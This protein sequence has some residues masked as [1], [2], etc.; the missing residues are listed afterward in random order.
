M[1]KK[2]LKKIANLATDHTW[3]MG[4]I[5]LIITFIFI[6]LMSQLSMNMNMTSL[7]PEGDPMVDEFN[8]IFE[9]FNGSSNVFIVA[10]GDFEDM[11][12]YAEALKPQILD[13]DN[14]IINN[15]S[16]EL[17]EQ[18]DK[19]Q[20]KIKAGKA[21]SKD[22]LFERVDY[23]QPLDYMRDHGLMLM[24]PSDIK[25]SREMFEDPNF[26]P[27]LVNLN[28]SLEK[29]YIQ[30]EEKISTQQKE[31]GA[32]AFLDGI[33][34]WTDLNT[35]YYIYGEKDVQTLA[36]ES[37]EALTLGSPYFISPDRSML[38]IQAMPTFSMM[39]MN[40]LLPGVNAIEECAKSLATEHN[41]EVGL[42]GSIVLGRDEY[43]AGLADSM[44]L[45][46]I[47]LVGIFV[48]FIVTFRM[49]AAPLLAITNLIIG[50]IWAMGFTWF[51]VDE[52]NMFTAMM[53]VVLVGLGIDYSIH[54]I[55]VYSELRNKGVV[56]RE[57]ME[58]T[59]EK[60][61]AGIITGAFT[62]S[63]AFFTLIIARSSG[64][65]EFGLVNGVGLVVVMIATL[66]TLPVMLILRE[67]YRS[68]RKK[69]FKQTR[70]VSYR[71]A[72]KT[73]VLIRN[74]RKP[75]FII[76]ALV[77]ILALFYAG[78]VTMDY[79]YLNMEPEGL[80]SILLNEE[81]IEAF[82]MSSDQTLM[83]ATSLEENRRFEQEAKEKHSISFVES[84][85]SFL[86]LES[87]Q[88]ERAVG[89]Q[90]IHDKMASTKIS[91]TP[92]HNAWAL[93]IDELIRLE[94]N[95]IELQDLSFIGGQDMVDKKATRLVGNP[96]QPEIQGKLTHLIAKLEEIGPKEEM[97]V[98]WHQAFAPAYREIV[99]DMADVSILTLADLPS[100]ISEKFISKD[101]SRYLMTIYPKGNVWHIDYLE[102]HTE[103]VLDISTSIAGMP[104]M[105]YYLLKIMGA[106][107]A[108]A[109]GL[110]IIVVIFFLWLDFRSLKK[111]LL[112]LVPLAFGLVW[113]LGIMGLTGVQFTL[114]N[115]IALP[116]IVGIGI[117]DGVH[118]IHRYE[119]EGPKGL[120]TV[121]ASTG[122]AVII[123]SLTTMI[124]F[125]SLVF[126]V[127]RG[128]G[129]MGIALFIG[130]GVCLAAS[131]LI[132]PA[133]LGKIEE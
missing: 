47:A 50:I 65:S 29:E 48:L 79:N 63:A 60:V 95:V 18:I 1:R 7:L 123:T 124:S 126:A 77:T 43:V 12:S 13:L 88:K 20:E 125:G 11:I 14:W 119:L 83:T 49:L 59:L 102:Q 33:E 51:L 112:A 98:K 122:K 45:T 128:F 120:Y 101:G 25:N 57:A 92:G 105:F 61:G 19:L 3:K 121:F 34:S 87:E 111:A 89:V 39:D 116:L 31:R 106:D 86:P 35:R 100:D 131:L 118:I 78:Q 85:T 9:E 91:T 68:M 67:K 80:E 2:L 66:M 103:D 73:A 30:S 4:G 84:I 99:L 5:L 107:G 113:M 132:L 40:Y 58:K 129:S 104:P 71:L 56:V 38:I 110:T 90:A 69:E 93:F 130:V 16:D 97:L 27:F 94:A 42:T 70:D 21:E 24:K 55:S 115:I 52:L 64:M 36:A 114:L 10:K 37:A 53:A 17:K 108:R 127:Y 81:L 8:Y 109:M 75:S 44:S 28:N 41:V 6:G 15:G 117:D 82:N 76:I 62:T 23:K 72:G 32:V 22:L 26:L 54:I 74:N 133:F 96:D 46:L